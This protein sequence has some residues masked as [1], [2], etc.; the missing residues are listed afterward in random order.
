[1]IAIGAVGG[2]A[3]GAVFG[4]KFL[5][6]AA[7]AKRFHINRATFYRHYSAI[8]GATRTCRAHTVTR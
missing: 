2:G 6:L 1:L 3:G 5:E 7:L 8:T 4:K